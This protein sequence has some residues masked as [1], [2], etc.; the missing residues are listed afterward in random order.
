MTFNLLYYHF[1]I[2]LSP[3]G[4]TIKVYRLV[5]PIWQVGALCFIGNMLD[6]IMMIDTEAT[7]CLVTQDFFL[8]VRFID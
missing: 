2:F 1:L 5:R 6:N 7:K 3:K 8:F 4:V